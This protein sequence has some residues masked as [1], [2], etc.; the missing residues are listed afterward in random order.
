[1]VKSLGADNLIDYNTSDLTQSA[2]TYDV[3]TDAVG[4]MPSSQAKRKLK[5][6]GGYLNGLTSSGGLKLKSEHLL[7]L[8]QLIEE[9]QLISVIDR[10]YPLEKII[11]AHRYVEKE[12]KK[13]NVIITIR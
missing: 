5:N 13:G 9:N 6:K 4:K 2:Q 7:F 10:R 1:M 8:K 12:H 3:I 11:E